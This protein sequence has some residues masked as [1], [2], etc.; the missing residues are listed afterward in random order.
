MIKKERRGRSYTFYTCLMPDGPWVR[1]WRE[2]YVSNWTRGGGGLDSK[3]RTIENATCHM[4]SFT[5][6]I[7]S[8]LISAHTFLSR[9][10]AI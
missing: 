6:N 1:R 4:M 2:I 9:S 10:L 8:H 3:A 7:S 5:R